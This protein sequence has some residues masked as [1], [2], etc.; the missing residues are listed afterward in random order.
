[1]SNPKD[2]FITSNPEVLEAVLHRKNRPINIIAGTIGHFV[3]WYDWYIYGLLAVIFA[4]QIFPSSSTFGSLI[5]ALLTYA[6]LGSSRN[7]SVGPESTTALLTATAVG[8]LAASDPARYAALA[9]ALA[10]LVGL[11]CL[12]AWLLRLGVLAD[13]L[14][15]PV[16]IGYMAG[17]AALMVVSQ[18]ET[19]TGVPVDGGSFAGATSSFLRHLDDL[20]AAP[21]TVAAA[22]PR[23]PWR[24]CARSPESSPRCGAPR[25]WGSAGAPTAPRTARSTS[26]SWSA[27]P[28]GR[29][30]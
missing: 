11:I 21:T 8:P 29:P 9:V 23:R 22:T 16:L 14:S 12:A 1:M 2:E 19:V 6:V 3:E 24:S 26:G 30:A 4:P 5:A 28:P 7:L 17:I 10:V 27:C 25:W 18:L 15:R 20:Q 13:A